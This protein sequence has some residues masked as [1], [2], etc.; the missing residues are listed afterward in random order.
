MK[1]ASAVVLAMA[2]ACASLSGIPSSANEWQAA[3]G[4]W[5]LYKKNCAGCHG[6]EGQG[7]PP[8]G[9]P[10]MGNQILIN[11]PSEVV[12]Q[13]IRTGRRGADKAYPE[14]VQA[15]EG[16]YM[17]MPPFG[18]EVISDTQLQSLVNYLKGA[19]QEGQ[20]NQP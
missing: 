5:A 15:L 10:L 2:L 4:A 7:I 17:W 6:F 19:F 13:I 11:A 3:G 18:P 14:N 16:G 8:V 1:T 12:A 9:T 20:F